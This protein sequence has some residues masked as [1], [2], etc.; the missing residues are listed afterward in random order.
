[1][2]FYH[3]KCPFH[4]AV[5]SADI[6]PSFQL[7]YPPHSTTFSHLDNIKVPRDKISSTSQ[8]LFETVV[9]KKVTVFLD[10]K[11]REPPTKLVVSD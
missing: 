4:A 1:M 10:R 3:P 2:S 7:L 6:L 9:I 8:F 11:T 5:L